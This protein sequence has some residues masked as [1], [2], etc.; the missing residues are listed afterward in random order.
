M[1]HIHYF[2]FVCFAIFGNM[3]SIYG[4]GTSCAGATAFALTSGCIT[5]AYSFSS[6]TTRLNLG[7]ACGSTTP[8]ETGWYTFT[9]PTNGVV[10]I[11]GTVGGGRDLT[12]SVYTG[13]TAGTVVGC[14]DTNGN[15]ANE[16][17][18][19]LAVTGGQVYNVQLGRFTGTGGGNTTGTIC[20]SFVPANNACTSATSL[21]PAAIGAACTTTNGTTLGATQS[22]A[23][24]TTCGA[25]TTASDDDVWYSFD[26]TS[27]S[28]TVTVTPG[29]LNNPTFE[30]Y[31]GGVS[32]G[33]CP[34]NTTGGTCINGSALAAGAES[35]TFA[36]LTIG[37][38]Y[39]VRVYSIG[40]TTG[41][42]GTFTICVATPL[43]NDA[44]SNAIPLTPSALSGACVT[45]NGS[46]VGATASGFSA[47]CASATADDDVWYRFDATATTHNIKVG[48]TTI[49]DIAFEL[50]D[51][52]V[53]P[54][55]CPVA[56]GGTCINVG[57]PVATAD[58][59]NTFTSLIVGHRYFVRVYSTGN[60][61]GQGT[62][63]I[64]VTTPALGECLN[65]IP[66]T[67]NT[68]CV[69]TTYTLTG[70]DAIAAP[71]CATPT[72]SGWYSFTATSTGNVN[73]DFTGNRRGILAVYTGNCTALTEV[74]CTFTGTNSNPLS[75][76][77]SVTSG[78]TYL[79]RIMKSNGGANATGTICAYIQPP[80]NDACTNAISLTSAT[81]CINTTGTSTAATQ[82]QPGCTGTADDDVWYS[83]IAVST[84]HT[85][86]VTPTATAMTDAVVELFSGTCAGLS[87]LICQNTT[88]AAAAEVINATGLTIGN[89]YFVRVYSQANA[90]GQ[91]DFNIC[92]THAVPSNDTCAGAIS[93]TPSGTCNPTRAS[94]ISATQTLAGCTGTAD[95]DVWFSFVAANTTQ[96]ITVTPAG[97][98]PMSGAVFQVFSVC[99]STTVT[100]T[101]TSATGAATATATV[102]GLI[103]GN[104]YFVRVFSSG[105]GTGQGNFDI[106]IVTP[107][108]GN[109][110]CSTA[111]SLVS[112]PT[113]TNT[114]S[115]TTTATAGTVGCAGN[116]DDD[117]WFSF[118]AQ[119]PT[120]V[121]TLSP[122]GATPLG[123]A[124]VELLQG[125]CPTPATTLVCQ[126]ATTVAATETLTYTSLVIGTTY[127]IR[128][129]SFANTTGKGT[130]NICVTHTPP[131]NDECANAIT[132]TP[133]AFCTNGSNIGA[134]NNPTQDLVSCSIGGNELTVWYK[135]VATFTTHVVRVQNSTPNFDLNFALYTG[136]CGSL[137]IVGAC[138]NGGGNGSAEINTFT[139]LTVG[140]TYFVRIA[141]QVANSQGDFC[142]QVYNVNPPNDNCENP[143]L[144]TMN[145]SCA[146]GDN[147]NATTGT[148]NGLTGCGTNSGTLWY[149]F[150]ATQTSHY[151]EINNVYSDDATF[152]LYNSNCNL[153]TTIGTCITATGT[154]AGNTYTGLT[155]GATYLIRVS[156]NVSRGLF[157]IKVKSAPP[158]DNCANAV[159]LTVNNPCVAGTNTLAT[160]TAPNPAVSCGNN[161]KTAWYSFV[162][163]GTSQ[164]VSLT[165]VSTNFD[166]A[167]QVYTK[168]G[169]CTMTAVA[170]GCSDTGGGAGG[171]ETL[172]ITTVPGTTYYVMVFGT[173]A[174]NEGDFCIQVAGPPIN[175]LCTN[176]TTLT[177]NASCTAGTNVFATNTAGEPTATCGNTSQTVWYSFVATNTTHTI[178]L[179]NVQA[180]EDLTFNV[181]NSGLAINCASLTELVCRDAA[182]SGGSET[183]TLTNFIIG[184]LY[185]IRVKGYVATDAGTFCVQVISPPVNDLCTSATSLTMNYPC[186]LGSNIGATNT[187]L[188]PADPSSAPFCGNNAATVWYSFVATQTSHRISAF[189]KSTS[190]TNTNFVMNLYSSSNNSCSGTLTSLACRNIN[191]TGASGGEENLFTGL[192]VGN[193][194]FII[195]RGSTATDQASFCIS[196]TQDSDLCTNAVPL[197]I[198]GECIAAGN[199]NSTVG[200]TAGET[201]TCSGG[202]VTN[203]M[204]F[205]F[206][207]TS[208]TT[209][210]N[211]QFNAN[212]DGRIT[213][214]NAASSCSG[215][216]QIGCQN[217]GGNG[218]AE[219]LTLNQLSI[220]RTYYVLVDATGG[221]TGAFCIKTTSNVPCGTNPLPAD[222]CNAAPLISNL[223]G[224]CG[225]TSTSLYSQGF[226]NNLTSNSTPFCGGTPTIENN[227]FL[228]FTASSTTATF[229]L[230][231][232]SNAPNGGIPCTTGVQMQILSVSGG[233]CRTGTWSAVPGTCLNTSGTLGTSSTVTA[234]GLIPGQIYYIM[235][236]GYAGQECGYSMNT[237]LG[238]GVVLPV[239]LLN[240][241]AK[242]IGQSNILRWA[243]TSQLN[244]KYFQIDRSYNG[245]E[246]ET[247]G[248]TNAAGTNNSLLNY[249]FVDSKPLHAKNYYRLTVVDIDGSLSFSQIVELNP[250]DTEFSLLKLYPN[251]ANQ[252]I[253]ATIFSKE[254]S[255][256]LVEIINL[257]GRVVLQTER[258]LQMNNTE[259]LFDLANF[260]SGLYILK[261]T[262]ATTGNIVYQKFVKQ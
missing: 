193:T 230:N 123:D 238:A 3:Q 42:Q 194:Y 199:S 79:V 44:C 13:C 20:I 103:S 179:T 51:G 11:T 192:T 92:V 55:T 99:S 203:A 9:A 217:A 104:T 34:G 132:L 15:N 76:V 197:N 60:G 190:N 259:L 17:I 168:T 50:Y 174:S 31:N 202:A 172:A 113:C 1:K 209:T 180:G 89:T 35:N 24:I 153:L 90:A 191:G 240:F 39:F 248:R 119:S 109:D 260:S 12:L 237:L 64:C 170:S 27:T 65:P 21:T 198:N 141:N 149:S 226:Y 32:P 88:T 74:A 223:N 152:Q 257:D 118:V 215:L 41:V 4:Q 130:F 229:T 117:V 93:L 195:I 82:S 148:N 224:Y 233:D 68:S 207:P 162:A 91:G 211:V 222:E 147:T 177:V 232:T 46:T 167:F 16:S 127:F 73:L 57:T 122:T 154:S 251:P 231:I 67:V 165:G 250:K 166:A 210:V 105:N 244:A 212:V 59:S 29:T 236:D 86:T 63:T 85:I 255:K 110:A 80:A 8:T 136:T 38:R 169:N 124:V 22:F 159:S 208:S 66:L 95:D 26:A 204:W 181:Y 97:G 134:S 185:L 61:T 70:L 58:E 214:F 164:T 249:D 157:C 183:S 242:N 228:R 23:A 220:G 182:S 246:F 94:S 219:N 151:V 107:I 176:A 178:N 125:T 234:T 213:I 173:D 144:L 188:A 131:A 245:L 206:V 137:S 175:D 81:T 258:E 49:T 145:G 10:N 120:H 28:H 247:I 108:I 106:C 216:T 78:T 45:T 98:L 261:I 128:V 111:T 121:V 52:G 196:V 155:F 19:S 150:V 171:S 227:S 72:Q 87:T 187:T 158:N 156:T 116:A 77:V 114:S 71:S 138:I 186:Q 184:N 161:T 254:T 101:C 140:T 200:A 48:A 135:F 6:T 126:N 143:T 146:N 43:V 115:T 69:T 18:T 83:F 40:N 241:S 54:G 30:L 47:S 112:N 84:S 253:T 37:N 14:A 239:E 53:S 96:T 36:G 56:A 102:A 189:P 256:A 33:T 7:A 139:G 25:A 218:V 201:S 252:E 129:Y 163:T 142:V 160:N 221:A 235:F 262:S 205:S 75:L 133:T 5:Q 62:F 243:T 100:G 225:V 2:L